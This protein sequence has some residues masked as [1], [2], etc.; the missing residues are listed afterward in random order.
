MPCRSP[1]RLLLLSAVALLASAP[2]AAAE[3][4]SRKPA[5]R[6]V[7]VYSARHYRSDAALYAAF[8]AKTGIRVNRVDGKEEEIFERIRAEGADGPADVFITVDAARLGHAD[9]LGLFQPLQSKLLEARIPAS[10]RTARWAAFS[11]RARL[12]VYAKGAVDPALLRTYEDLAAPALRG[13]LCA[14]SGVHPYNL[15]LGAA[16]LH[17]LGEARTEEWARGLVANLARPPRGSDPDQ[18]RAVAAGECQVT[19]ANSYYV[20]RLLHSERAEDREAAAKLG[21]VWPNQQSFGAH[22]N[23]SAGGVLRS[24]RHRAEAVAFLEY[25]AG[26]EAQAHFADGNDEWPAVKTVKGTNAALDSLGA[27][28]ADPL[29]VETLTRNT[30]AVWKVF[31]RAGWR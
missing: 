19:L 4:A 22:V 8:T 21:V 20:A 15:S 1:S 25:L 12:I 14:R 11:T 13:K 16:L 3:R 2:A 28:K 24:A 5:E 31:E 23:V 26:D 17:H 9:A 29:D 27:F 10:L 7:S 6:V 30:L 18:L